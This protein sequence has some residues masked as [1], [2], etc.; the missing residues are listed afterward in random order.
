MLWI[1]DF[2]IACLLKGVSMSLSLV[3]LDVEELSYLINFISIY[4]SAWGPWAFSKNVKYLIYIPPNLYP[5]EQTRD[6]L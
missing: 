6:Q 2:E 4:Y 1:C 5:T 3:L